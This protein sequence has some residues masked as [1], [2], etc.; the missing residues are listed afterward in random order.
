MS[1]KCRILV[2]L[3]SCL[4]LL[5]GTVSYALA[6]GKNLKLG[7]FIVDPLIKKSDDGS[8]G[9]SVIRVIERIASIEDWELEYVECEFPQCLR[10]LEAAEIDLM[11]SITVTDERRYRFD[12]TEET[13]FMDWGQIYT[14]QEKDMNSVLDL[15]GK[16][17]SV[18]KGTAQYPPF[19][20]LLESFGVKIETVF[21]EDYDDVFNYVVNGKADALMVNR[22]FGEKNMKKYRVHRTPIIFTPMDIRYATPKGKHQDVRNAIDRNLIRLKADDNSEYYHAISAMLGE[23]KPLKYIPGWVKWAAAG[24]MGSL[25]FSILFAFILKNQVNLRTAELRH[26]N[27]E[28]RRAERNLFES[29]ESFKTLVEFTAAIHWELDLA[30]GRF[31]YVSPQAV[32]MLGYPIDAWVGLEFWAGIIHPEDH[33]WAYEFCTVETRK[34]NDHEFTYRVK[35][36]D[37]HTVWLRDIV[38]VIKDDKGPAK[39]IGIMFDITEQKNA[40]EKIEASLKEKEVLLK[41]IHHRVKNNMAIITSLS[42]LQSRQLKDEEA[43]RILK[44]GRDRIRAMALVHEQLYQSDNLSDISVKQYLVRLVENVAKSY[45]LKDREMIRIQCDDLRLNIDTLVPCGLIINELLTNSLKYA[46]DTPGAGAI[47]VS[48]KQSGDNVCSLMVRDQG[49]GFP[50]EYDLENQG[51]LGLQLVRSLASQLEGTLSINNEEGVSVEFTFS[52]AVC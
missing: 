35:D 12:Y 52:S 6:S 1:L 32:S 19:M 3:L 36:S 16:R 5:S 39:L 47:T 25:A 27:E 49:K 26:E 28:R 34:G 2:L 42:S 50:A 23:G 38:K 33:D 9:G 10:M 18:L 31:T 44:E 51:S 24:I 29:R 48:M 13:F 37:G 17:V 20:K 4:F 46:Y 43:V 7:V 14:S 21:V 45:T 30:S 22:L 8:Y 11:G 41:E 15:E 40:E